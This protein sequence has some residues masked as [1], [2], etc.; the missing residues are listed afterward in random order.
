MEKEKLEKRKEELEGLEPE[1]LPVTKGISDYIITLDRLA[2]RKYIIYG[3]EWITEH[4]LNEFEKAKQ[5]FINLTTEENYF[6]DENINYWININKHTRDLDKK[7]EEIKQLK[8][9][10]KVLQRHTEKDITKEQIDKKQTKQYIKQNYIGE[11]INGYKLQKEP[12][13]GSIYFHKE[14]NDFVIYATPYFDT[15]KE[16]GINIQVTTHNGESLIIEDI[17]TDKTPEQIRKNYMEYMKE[18]I[19][20]KFTGK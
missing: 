10:I 19:E 14:N 1:D 18:Y 4:E 20:D 7:K 16:E 6:F 11:T 3:D 15:K 17:H 9:K 5:L 8:S 12:M 2:D 13:S